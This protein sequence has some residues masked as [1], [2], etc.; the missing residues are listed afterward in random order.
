MSLRI[1]LPLKVLV[2]YLAVV[3]VGA[4]PTF[5][6]LRQELT[7]QLLKES[8][9][10]LAERG[11]RMARI[12]SDVP[13]DRRFRELE[14]LAD[15]TPER[16]TLIAPVGEVSFDTHAEQG[17]LR[18]HAS[19]PEVLQ[20]RSLTEEP[21]PGTATFLKPRPGIGVARRVSETT[22]IDSLYVAVRLP[23]EPAASQPVLRVARRVD[24]IS[25]VTDQTVRFLR[26]A[27][28]FAISVALGLSLLA[29]V[30]FVRPLIRLRSTAEKLAAGDFG[31]SAD[32][33]PI[34]EIGDLGRSLLA[35]AAEMR[36]RMATSGAGEAM[37]V[38]LVDVLETPIVIF[39]VDGEVIALNGPARK[40]LAVEGPSAGQRVRDLLD[41]VAFQAALKQAEEEG[42]PE[43]VSLRA[44]DGVQTSVRVFVL[45]R[46]GTAPLGLLLG[47]AD[48]RETA[49]LPAVD[50]VRPRSLADLIGE[51][52]LEVTGAFEGVGIELD[53]PVEL[54]AVQL[55]DADGRLADALL[56]TLRGCMPAFGGRPG[57]LSLDVEV[58]DTR[59]AVA[60]DAAPPSDVLARVRPLLEPL[61]GRI[62]VESGEAT[63][64]LPRA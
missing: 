2:S 17:E 20:A 39:Q 4:V 11:R 50:D 7:H 22:G 51:V 53:A 1:P 19:R 29:A 57:K 23:G 62:F 31:A 49:L 9:E 40:L 16:L 41:D 48:V 27:Q 52:C 5:F 30:V 34:D 56:T 26:N 36:R 61:G 42:H 54:P 60:L 32:I 44:K 25:D 45:K 37:L 63:L 47:P 28:A 8:G 14:R 58:E 18:S 35:L 59:V 38:Q 3:A 12:L 10:R 21:V 13:P 6:Y 15:L 55:A 33:S 43:P 46:P 64:W 24:T